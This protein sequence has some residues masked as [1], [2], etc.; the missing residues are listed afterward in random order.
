MLAASGQTGGIP[1]LGDVAI[2]SH[3]T[4]MI[5][6]G[7]EVSRQIDDIGRTLHAL[8]DADATP[9][10]LRL[11]VAE[12]IG[13]EKYSS[14]TAYAEAL[15]YYARPGR[16]S[17][18]QALYQ[19]CLEAPQAA[20]APPPKP[21]DVERPS[22]KQ[23]RRRRP[24]VAAAF[25]MVALLIAGALGTAAWIWRADP[26]VAGPVA[27]VR[28]AATAAATAVRQIASDVAP[29]GGRKGRRGD[30]VTIV[31]GRATVSPAVH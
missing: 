9:M 8:L 23:P 21:A 16:R 3:G 6:Q 13:S 31:E 30:G 22:T 19:R 5:R 1:D 20:Q 14:V 4:V 2:T 24:A 25:A 12:S 29:A 18:I 26:R 27:A 11:F 10:P 28:S 7:A 17:L 15:A